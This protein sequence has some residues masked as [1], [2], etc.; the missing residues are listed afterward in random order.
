MGASSMKTSSAKNKGRKLQQWVMDK[1]RKAI[2]VEE[3]DIQSRSMGAGGEDIMLSPLARSKFPYSIECKNVE[4]LNVWNAYDQAVANSAEYIPLLI[5]K[6]N[7]RMP[8]AVFKAD[9]FFHLIE[10][11]NGY[12]WT[13]ERCPS[14]A[15]ME[16]EDE[17]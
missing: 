11:L 16:N 1:L 9:H 14:H 17:L 2:R 15:T 13:Q 10:L 12:K 5:M 6:K 3:D 8:L 7:R 4:R